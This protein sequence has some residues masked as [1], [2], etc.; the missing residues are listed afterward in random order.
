M[1]KYCL[2]SPTMHYRQLLHCSS[3]ICGH[4]VSDIHAQLRHTKKQT[5]QIT[6]TAR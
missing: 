4:H 2:T 3:V 6:T 1:N 5:K